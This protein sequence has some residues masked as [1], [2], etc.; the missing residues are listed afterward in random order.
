[1]LSFIRLAA[2]LQCSVI[3][4]ATYGTESVTKKIVSH[5]FEGEHCS[6]DVEAETNT[7]TIFLD[8]RLFSPNHR[9]A[10]HPS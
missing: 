4:A 8:L 2:V 3:V 1:M 9:N 5:H 7:T 6:T 10:S